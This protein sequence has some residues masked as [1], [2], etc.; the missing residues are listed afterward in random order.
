MLNPRVATA[1][2]AR[3]VRYQDAEEERLG[4]IQ[5]ATAK[6]DTAIAKN[7]TEQGVAL[8]RKETR[9]LIRRLKESMQ[10]DH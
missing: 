3:A 7:T 4:R 5:L 9:Y 8:S 2:I 1:R 6:I 10:N